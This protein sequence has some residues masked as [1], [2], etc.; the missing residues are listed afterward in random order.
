MGT[1]DYF[2]A[3]A[4]TMIENRK[5][6][7]EN[8]QPVVVPDVYFNEMHNSNQDNQDVFIFKELTYDQELNAYY[9]GLD[10]L[11]RKYSHF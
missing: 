4:G 8:I 2:A 6:F 11:K 3:I 10:S 7:M 1:N 5:E 9:S